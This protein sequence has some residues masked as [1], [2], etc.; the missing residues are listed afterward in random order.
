MSTPHRFIRSLLDLGARFLPRGGVVLLLGT[1]SARAISTCGLLVTAALLGPAPY[2][3]LGVYVGVLSLLSV[4]AC[5]RYEAAILAVRDERDA[6]SVVLLSQRIC[7]LFLLAVSA[8]CALAVAM[9]WNVPLGLPA[10]ALAVLPLGIFARVKLRI[11]S[12]VLT[13]SGRPRIRARGAVA[14]SIAQ[15]LVTLAIYGM[16]VDPVMA[17]VLGDCVGHLV[18]ASI[19]RVGNRAWREENPPRGRLVQ[20]AKAWRQMPLPGLPNAFLSIAFDAAPALLAGLTL[21]PHLGGQMILALR[22][23][24]IPGFLVS[25]VAV[26]TLQ[27]AIVEDRTPLRYTLRPVLRLAVLLGGTFLAIAGAAHVL[28]PLLLHTRW[29]ELFRLVQWFAPSAALL[30]F[31]NPL[32]ELI[33]IYGVEVQAFRLHLASLFVLALCTG[34]LLVFGERV[35]SLALLIALAALA[36]VILFA[37]LLVA[38]SRIE[39]ERVARRA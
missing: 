9:G 10:A 20:H 5:G 23:L 16:A 14:Q 29:P 13:R 27:R 33:A 39:R 38:Q 37:R 21:P 11:E 26:P 4:A 18:A 3:A 34:G 2:A 15:P 31:I 22:L 32:I 30:A 12:L 17:L 35:P 6:R 25:F 19:L 1:L 28:S 36:R 24:D 7:A 8:F